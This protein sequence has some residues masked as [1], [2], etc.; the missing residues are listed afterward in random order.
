MSESQELAEALREILQVVAVGIACLER[1]GV[2][3]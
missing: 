3:R 2:E 1:H